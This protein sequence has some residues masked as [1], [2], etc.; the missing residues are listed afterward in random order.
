[1]GVEHH[2][3]VLA[4]HRGEVRVRHKVAACGHL[5]RDALVGLQKTLFLTDGLA[6]R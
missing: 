5:A 4:Q 1:M 6:M 3:A 2:D